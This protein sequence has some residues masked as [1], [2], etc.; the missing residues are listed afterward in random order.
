LSPRKNDHKA[1]VI[2]R[3]AAAAR[4]RVAKAKADTAARFVRQYYANVAPEDL[5]GETAENLLGAVL[6]VWSFMQT[7]SGAKPK[8]RVFNP[9]VREHG[10]ESPHTIIEIVND[11]MPFLVDSV[12]GELNRHG[13]TVQIV[14]HPVL[15]ISRGKAGKL[16]DLAAK[17][18][19]DGGAAAESVMHIEVNQQTAPEVLRG[20]HADLV[21]VLG[22]VRAA[23]NDWPRM[24]RRIAETLDDLDSV[25]PPLEPAQVEEARAFL[26]WIADNHFTFLGYREYAIAS[27]KNSRISV[28]PGTGLGILRKSDFTVF[29]ALKDNAALPIE[30]AD[31]IRK[32]TLLMLGKANRRS[33]VHRPVHLDTIGIKLFNRAGRVVGE[34]LF[35]GLFTSDVYNEGAR[36]IPLVRRKVDNIVSR[37]GF[38]PQSHN[39]KAL[40]NILET[41]P[42]DELLQVGD[43]ALLATS[44]GVLQLQ[45]RQR[46]KLFVHPDPYGHYVSCLV[47]APRDRYDTKL[48]GV[49]QEI[50]AEGFGGVV[51]AYYTQLTDAP[52]ARVQ[53]IVKTEPGVAAPQSVEEM[54]KRLVE[55]GRDWADDFCHHL[56]LQHGEERGLVLHQSHGDA[57]PSAYREQ[58]D[59]IDAVADVVQIEAALRTDGIGMHLYRAGDSR[60]DE[61]R[62]K[63]YHRHSPLPL[64]DVLPML[65]NMGLRVI[66]EVPHRITPRD[67]D[68]EVWIHDFGLVIRT[69]AAVDVE[70]VKEVFED[71]FARIWSGEM[72]NDGFNKLVLG[73]GLSWRQVVILRAYCRFLLQAAI[74]YSQSY[75]EETL[76]GNPA[77]TRMIV[78]LFGNLFDPAAQDS[79]AKSRCARL[80]QRIEKALEAVEVLDEDRILRRFANAVESTLRTNFYQRT[81]DGAPKPYLSFKLDSGALDD[82]PLPRPMVEVF[83]HSPRV[84][85]IHLRGGM[86]ARG[87]IRWS[88]RRE[89][90]R[91]EILGLMKSQMTKNAVIVPFGAKGGFVLK[92]QPP[93]GDRAAYQAEGIACYKTMMRGLLDITDNLKSGRIEAPESVVRRDGDDPYLVVAADKGTATFSDIANEMAAEYGFWLDDAFASGGS[94]GYDHKAMGITARGAW[95]SV[96]RHFR[97]LGEDIQSTD[98]TCLG[99]GD[100]AGD[101]FGNGMLCSQHTK[102]VG[103]FNHMHIF[104]DPDPDPRVSYRERRRLFRM[105]RSSWTD[106]NAKLISRGGGVFARSAKSIKITP[107]MRIAFDLAAKPAM[108]PNEL[109][110]AMLKAPVDMLWLGG[111][112][113]FVKGRHESSAE[114][115][116]KAN[117]ALRIDGAELRCKVVGEGANLGVTQIGRI[118]YALAGGRINTDFIDNSAGVGCSDHE[119]NMKILFGDAIANNRLTMPQRNKLLVEMTDEV[120]ELVLT[121]N[122]RQ[123]MALTH[124]EHQ[125]VAMLDE[126]VRFM[127]SLERTGEL[128]RAVEF[129]PDDE[130]IDERRSAGL[131][132]VRPELSV[133]LAYAKNS[134][135]SELLESDV[136]DDPH[137]TND[138]GLYFPKAMRRRF[139]EFVSGHRLQRE[140]TATYVANTV[141]NR[142]GPSFINDVKERTGASASEIARAY[143]ICRRVF[144]MAELWAG[145]ESL[146]NSVPAEIQTAMQ[147]KVLNLIKRGT[148]WFLRS[149]LRPLAIDRTVAAFEPGVAALR[150]ALPLVLSPELKSEIDRQ[151]ESYADNRVPAD[152]ARAVASLDALAPACDIVRIAA[153]GHFAPKAV[154]HVYYALGARFGFDWLRAAAD[155]LT[156]GSE[157]Q[158]K[159]ALAIFDDLYSHQTQLANRVLDDAGGPEVV[160]VVVDAW[161][162]AHTAPVDRVHSI[163]AELRMASAVDLAMLAVANREI[164]TLISA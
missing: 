135:F 103:A 140:I 77:V 70:A 151:A 157:W 134:L 124:A 74:P 32:P 132:F 56:I 150:S 155:T 52:L 149:G 114:V 91:T 23:V 59:V 21:N 20:I 96:K 58:F 145:V 87:G 115:G 75:M 22:D 18:T 89:D 25:P 105:P 5:T 3:L 45:E 158:H 47:Y 26:R 65:E 117:D 16:T 63:M 94:V 30:I 78:D 130:K 116:D 61:I 48:R 106:Y 64:S 28:V 57:F 72:Q 17:R 71:A 44:L 53:I 142:A 9:S 95:E 15:W 104:I 79:G 11:D 92:Q 127:E 55:A 125:S 14:I 83:V 146:D 69:G 164:R 85:A 93:P 129:L 33:T 133:L 144:H 66:D 128:D 73:V 7:R 113:T 118:E 123:S 39:A 107:Q 46:I 80:R 98:F 162:A 111:I 141:I 139:A 29:D 88:D 153:A 43:D 36:G 109:I 120:A 68:H 84:E 6:S 101:V 35:A 152:L 159:A 112:G 100:M 62:F 147:L 148:L 160:D 42:R 2:R 126:H 121:D 86:V 24:R 156:S 99:V 143:L 76:E 81:N 49:M 137:L 97:E 82:L 154:A 108:P 67:A 40:L 34:R 10:F 54:E 31:F 51:T 19:Q 50:L 37:S 138:L 38:P 12:T 60:A 122:Y 90:F 102:L 110:R 161:A 41:L 131:G 8:I 136:P 119:V 163:V 1:A 13:L 27:T 4:R